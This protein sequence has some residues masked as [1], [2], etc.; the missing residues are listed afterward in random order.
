MATREGRYRKRPEMAIGLVWLHAQGLYEFV[1]VVNLS[2]LTP[3]FPPGKHSS[4]GGEH[5]HARR[6][7]IRKDEV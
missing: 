2:S 6:I 1:Q 4:C 7:P 5:R 3:Y